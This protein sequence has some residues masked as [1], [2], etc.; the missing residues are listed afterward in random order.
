MTNERIFVIGVDESTP[1]RKFKLV[2]S[3]YSD[4]PISEIRK[5]IGFP[6]GISTLDIEGF[7]YL[8]VATERIVKFKKWQI[9]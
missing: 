5:K 2:S 7:S 1:V 4:E 3:S 8:I 9:E 6:L